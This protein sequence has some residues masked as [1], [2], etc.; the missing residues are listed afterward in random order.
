MSVLVTHL[1]ASA[2]KDGGVRPEFMH[3][4]LSE[5]VG[6]KTQYLT[7]SVKKKRLMFQKL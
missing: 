2:Q 6:G 1:E 7:S 3:V 4:C 5:R